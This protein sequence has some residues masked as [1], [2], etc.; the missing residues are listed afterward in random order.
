MPVLVLTLA[1]TIL[2]S[3]GLRPSPPNLVENGEPFAGDHRWT[4]S[5][6]HEPLPAGSVGD[7][8][9]EDC[10]DRPCFAMRNGAAWNQVIRFRA[11]PAGKFLLIVA[12]GSS[13][14]VLPG[15]NVT[16]VPYLWAKLEGVKPWQAGVL[17]G[18]SL[19]PDA[20]Y[21]RGVI[22][23]IFRV[24]PGAYE[25][26]LML[27]QA[28]RRGTPHNG[29]AAWVKDVEVRLFETRKEATAYAA[30][31]AAQYRVAAAKED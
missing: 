13:E 24:P 7:A 28:L 22:L 4:R 25:M 12:Q 19:R 31:Y 11:D 27:G 18:M 5:R 2:S 1:L 14:R 3:Q 6:S 9:I 26:R 21:A 20:P 10:D 29:S 30:H 17:Q 15:G 23:G 8:R 16:G